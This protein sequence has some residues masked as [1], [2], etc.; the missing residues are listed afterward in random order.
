M[1]ASVTETSLVRSI[2]ETARQLAKH[3]DG[4]RVEG[5][6]SDSPITIYLDGEVIYW[7]MKKNA[8]QKWWITR[9][10]PAHFGGEE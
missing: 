1:R 10:D 5:G 7:A 4:V 8:R 2:L 3:D 9:W 6:L